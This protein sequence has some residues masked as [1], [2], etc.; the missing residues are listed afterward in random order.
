VVFKEVKA[1]LQKELTLEWR[2]KFALGGIL[3][4]VLS[5]VF[6]A[7]LSFVKVI[8]VKTWNALLWVIILF[9]STNAVSK[10]FVQED[11]S[12]RLYL[13]TLAS[14]QGI[15]LAKIIYHALLVWVV[16]LLALGV[17]VMLIGNPVQNMPLFIAGV[18]LGS[19]GLSSVLTLVSAIAA[20][21]ENNVTLM[22][23]LS[24]PVLLPLLITLIKLS[25]GAIDGL[26]WSVLSK[27]VIVL[28]LLNVVVVTLAYILFPYLWRD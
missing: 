25:G 8:D 26:A 11:Q 16:S 13:Y 14:P 19:I 12:K 3:L 5:T 28:G 9:V 7:Y 23:I 27:Y 10:A 2:S 15:I 18:S 6:V 21:T 4:Y 1:L 20:Q 24:F 22:S 17:Y